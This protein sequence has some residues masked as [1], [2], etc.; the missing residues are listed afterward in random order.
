MTVNNVFNILLSP[1]VT[2]KTSMS[3]HGY[4]Q[5]VF[6][7]NRNSSKTDILNA[8]QEVFDVK[9]RSVRTLN[10]KGKSVRFGRT[11]GK[12]SDWKKA[13]VTLDK[14]QDIDLS[15]KH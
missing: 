1:H 11:M 8:V 12:H 13:Y 7:V 9:V 10:V 6:K 14:G 2:E 4:R 15:G 3:S 5:F